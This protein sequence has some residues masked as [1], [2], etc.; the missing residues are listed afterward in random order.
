ME[1]N[2]S[3]KYILKKLIQNKPNHL[4]TWSSKLQKVHYVPY[5]YLLYFAPSKLLLRLP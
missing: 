1:K 4:D 3:A 2:V 5:T